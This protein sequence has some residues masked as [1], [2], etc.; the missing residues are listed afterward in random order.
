M[1]RRKWTLKDEG[2]VR[3]IEKALSI[4]KSGRTDSYLAA[5]ILTAARGGTP[6]D[7]RVIPL[8]KEAISHGHSTTMIESSL[9]FKV[10]LTGQPDFQKALLTTASVHVPDGEDPFIASPFKD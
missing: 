10:H 4:G 7:P 6:P 2:C 5:R 8:L 3:E 1:D 9:V